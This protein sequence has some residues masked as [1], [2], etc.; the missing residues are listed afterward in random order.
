M[1]V[2]IFAKQAGKIVWGF[3]HPLAIL[4]KEA[5]KWAGLYHTGP[6]GLKL[7]MDFIANTAP[8]VRA[9]L[10]AWPKKDEPQ[11]TRRKLI[12]SSL[13]GLIFISVVLQF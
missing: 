3:F 11:R 9:V 1:G 5:G 13:C 7:L 6:F 2:I 4:L 10:F 8:H 12:P